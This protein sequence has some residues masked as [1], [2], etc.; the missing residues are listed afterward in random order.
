MRDEDDSRLE[1]FS[2]GVEEIGDGG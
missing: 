2:N 1:L